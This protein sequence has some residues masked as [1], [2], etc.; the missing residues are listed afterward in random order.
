MV[1]PH[2]PEGVIF[3]GQRGQFEIG[4]KGS[5]CIGISSGGC[6]CEIS[7]PELGAQGGI[8]VLCPDYR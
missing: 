2:R 8:A 4:Q 1:F 5:L 7:V 6:R 3:I